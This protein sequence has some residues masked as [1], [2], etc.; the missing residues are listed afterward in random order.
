MGQVPFV[1]ACLWP[2]FHCFINS[3]RC[4]RG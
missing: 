1:Y 4:H 2:C 3:I